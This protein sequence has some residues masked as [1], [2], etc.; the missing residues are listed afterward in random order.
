[1]KKIDFEAPFV[2]EEW[3]E[4][5]DDRKKNYYRNAAQLGISP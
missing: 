1:M 2:T 5:L 3:I 4:T